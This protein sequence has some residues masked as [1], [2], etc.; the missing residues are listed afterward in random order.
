MADL[1][2]KLDTWVADGA[3]ETRLSPPE[4]ADAALA[5]PAFAAYLE[6]LDLGNGNEVVMWYRPE[7]DL[8]E[9]GV[10]DWYGG[11]GATMHLVLIDP[12]TGVVLDTVDRSWDRDADGF[13]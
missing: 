4:V 8:W 9:V 13:P 10:L 5:D 11:P 1:E 6:T 7:R 12:S 3:D 2:V